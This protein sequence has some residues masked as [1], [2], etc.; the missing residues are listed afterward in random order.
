MK[1][2]FK[3]G[4]YC[5]VIT[6]F[7]IPDLMAQEDK[8]RPN[9]NELIRSSRQMRELI[10]QD[11]HRPRYHLMPPEG[12]FNDANG[13]LFW[14]GR[15]HMFYLA[16]EPIPHPEKPGEE[17]WA[18]VWDHMSSRDLVHWVHHPPAVR[19]KQDGSTPK[20]IYSGGAIKNAPRPTLIYHVPGQGTCISVAEDDDLI[21]WK[22][23]PENPVIPPHTDD[24]EFIVFDPAGWYEDGTYY[25]IIGNKNKRPGY[26]GDCTSLFKSKDMINWEY[27]GPFY[28]SSREWTLEGED[29]ACPDFYPIGD[30]HML[31]MHDHRP[32]RNVTHYYLGTYKDERFLPEKYGKMSWIGGQLSGPESLIDDKGRNIFFGWMADFRKGVSSLYGYQRGYEWSVEQGKNLPYAWASVVSLPR[33]MSLREDGTLGIAPAPEFE[34]LRLNPKGFDNIEIPADKDVTVEGVS[35]N[36]MELSVQIDPGEA[37]EVGVKVLC[38]PDNTEQTVISYVPAEKKLKVDFTKSTVADNVEY[39]DYDPVKAEAFLTAGTEQAGPFE[40]KDGE[41][42][43]LRIFLDRSVLEVFANGRQCIT[44]RVYPSKENSTE[45]RLFSKGAAATAPMVEAWDIEPVAPW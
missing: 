27:Q 31:L 38:S 36:V 17:W 10:W 37:T 42:L 32:Y 13:A 35:G 34:S 30:K 7:L 22:E 33:V 8:G 3:Y 11:P 21:N 28:K 26:E 29:A 43:N 2:L 24:D 6:W 44:Q 16:R 41:T 39:R 23:L 1:R 15:Y 25:A 45:V 40:L 20:G 19:P 12:F 5:F 4:S 18:A 14:N 9:I